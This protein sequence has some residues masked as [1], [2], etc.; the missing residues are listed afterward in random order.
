MYRYYPEGTNYY[1]YA[2]QKVVLGR[3]LLL[4]NTAGKFDTL[5]NPE[6]ANSANYPFDYPIS[7]GNVVSL[8]FFSSLLYKS[9]Q[10][11][12]AD[13]RFGNMFLEK[14]PM[15]MNFIYHGAAF[16][17][18][19]TDSNPDMSIAIMD[20]VLDGLV[21]APA[22]PCN[23]TLGI[24]SYRKFFNVVGVLISRPDDLD[25]GLGLGFAIKNSGLFKL[26]FK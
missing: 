22:Y 6:S 24:K 26:S 19:K 5:A 10:I 1:Q 20:Y 12:I 18:N 11:N 9:I 25:I 3:E 4:L 15:Y 14:Y 16:D 8:S 2:M 23:K 21:R 13:D 7:T 17:F